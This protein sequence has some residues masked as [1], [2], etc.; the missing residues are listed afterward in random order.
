MAQLLS[1]ITVN[2]EQRWFLLSSILV[3][4]IHSLLVKVPLA[5]KMIDFSI[6]GSLNSTVAFWAH[7]FGST[8]SLAR[9]LARTHCQVELGLSMYIV[10][11]IASHT[12]MGIIALLEGLG[13]PRPTNGNSD[14]L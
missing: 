5:L 12:V 3:E 14:I 2:V 6:P 10:P 1:P 7:V 11:G 9:S 13:T 4:S 8:I